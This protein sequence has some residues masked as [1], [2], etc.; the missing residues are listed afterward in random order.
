MLANSDQHLGSRNL[1]PRTLELITVV[2]M[3]FISKICPITEVKQVLLP[4]NLVQ[5]ASHHHFCD[6]VDRL[7]SEVDRR[8][9]ICGVIGKKNSTNK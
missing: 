9:D 8:T 6:G 3:Y 5:T 7:A 1:E 4:T 2:G